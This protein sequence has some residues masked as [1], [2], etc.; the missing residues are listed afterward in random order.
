MHIVGCFTASLTDARSTPTLHKTAENVSRCYKMS[1][2]VPGH[3]KWRATALEP[4]KDSG[5]RSGLFTLLDS[6]GAVLRTR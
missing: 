6:S 1:T 4:N 3:M 5:I 2:E